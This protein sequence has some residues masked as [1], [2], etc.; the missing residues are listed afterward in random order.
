[1]C[2][3]FEHPLTTNDSFRRRVVCVCLL[4]SV[5]L[6]IANDPPSVVCLSVE[7][8]LSVCL[9]VCLS[10]ANDP[11]AMVCLSV[12]CSLS[13][14]SVCLS[15]DH[16][17]TILPSAALSSFEHSV[18]IPPRVFLSVRRTLLIPPYCLSVS[19]VP[20]PSLYVVCTSE[21]V[22][23]QHHVHFHGGRRQRDDWLS[24]LPYE[25]AMKTNYY[26]YQILLIL[27]EHGQYQY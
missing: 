7:Y 26:S 14:L 1:M 15:V 17:L 27:I 2:L 18:P 10:I 5:C 21:W 6:P 22:D 24:R 9:S 23:S 19:Y 16:S 3:S 13:S 4:Q 12:E 25:E 20:T 8:C 11:A